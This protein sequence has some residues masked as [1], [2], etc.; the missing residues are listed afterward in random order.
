[1]ANVYLALENNL[2][3]VPIINKIDLP[4]AD[5][6]KVAEEV[7]NT[8]GLDCKDA[9]RYSIQCF[10]TS[11]SQTHILFL[12]IHRASANTGIGIEAILEA[13][14]HRLPAPN[15]DRQKPLRF[16]FFH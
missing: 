12:L 8:I 2:E 6:A 10:I 5:P 14:V 13:I 11:C 7:E 9:I 1:M 16:S 3:I 4:A 15:A